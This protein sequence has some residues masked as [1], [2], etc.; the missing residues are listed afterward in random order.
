M[1]D[2]DLSS[3]CHLCKAPAL[4]ELDFTELQLHSKDDINQKIDELI[5]GIHSNPLEQ[6]V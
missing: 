3:G 1:N 5:L 2:Y 6:F 4:S